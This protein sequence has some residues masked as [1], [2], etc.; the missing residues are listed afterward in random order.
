MHWTLAVTEQN[1]GDKQVRLAHEVL[2]VFTGKGEVLTD[3]RHVIHY[4]YGG[5]V[6]GLRDVLEKQGFAVRPTTTTPGLIADRNE[7]TDP[8]WADTSMHMMCS[9]ADEF[10]A[11][12]DG[13][14]ASM[15]RQAAAPPKPTSWTQKLFG[16]RK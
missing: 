11:E 1:D 6:L 8:A 7:V 15:V 2:A 12:Y 3:E 13:W 5:D 16:K 4:F 9:L 14:E 10:G